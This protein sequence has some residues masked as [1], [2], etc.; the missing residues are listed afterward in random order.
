[1]TSRSLSATALLSWS[2]PMRR[3]PRRSLTSQPMPRR[4][5]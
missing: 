4:R 5:S 3:K 1:V 2:V